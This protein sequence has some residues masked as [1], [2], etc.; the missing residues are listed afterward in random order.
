M[1]IV[2]VNRWPRFSDGKRWDNELTR[3]E[4]FIDHDRH[5]VS[6]VVDALGEEGVLAA[7]STIASLVR[8]DD[9]NDFAS[10]R[11]AVLKITEHVGSVDQLIALSEFTLEIAARVREDLGLPGPTP[12]EVAVYRDKVRM[13]QVLAEAGVR[14]P[15]FAACED[16][17]RSRAFAASCGYPVIV[18]PVD[19]AASI[20]VHRVDDEA[21]LAQLL[22]TLDLGR[23]EVEEFVEGAVYHVDG[24][25]DEHARIRFQAV[26]RYVNDCLAFGTGSPLGSVIVQRSGLRNRIEEFAGRCVSALGMSTTPFHLELF[27]TPSDELVFLEIGGRVGGSEVPHLLNKLFDVNLFETWLRA[28]AGERIWLPDKPAD[29]SG[30]WLVLPKPTQLPARVL[31][32]TPM[33]EQVPSIWRELLPEVGDVLEPGGAY[34]ALHSGR[35]ILLHETQEQVEADIHRIIENFEFEASSL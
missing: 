30:G 16:A 9:V 28:L 15:R 10:L 33:R 4:E 8:V 29:P 12:A 13:K 25:V 22:P 35:F 20:G 14:V 17:E 11:A 27:V 24:F 7:P 1:H 3:Y 32:A 23:Y 34:D 2:I 31:K 19:G 26:S 21:A 6:Y 18:K 5:K